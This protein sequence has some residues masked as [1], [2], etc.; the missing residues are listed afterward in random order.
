MSINRT[1]T[2][3]LGLPG[4]TGVLPPKPIVPSNVSQTGLPKTSPTTQV[5]GAILDYL[6]IAAY[7]NATKGCN[8]N[9]NLGGAIP[10]AI[11][12]DGTIITSSSF[13]T[14]GSNGQLL[15]TF[16][17]DI[18]SSVATGTVISQVLYWQLLSQS[19]TPAN[20]PHSSEVSVTSGVTETQAESM[21]LS[22]G[23]KVGFNS[24]ITAEL[25]TELNQ[26]FTQEV[27]ISQ[28]TTLTQQFTFPAL[29]EEQVDGVYQLMRS[30][31]VSPGPNLTQFIAELQFQY[32]ALCGVFPTACLQFNGQFP[33]VYPDSVYLQVAGVDTT[34]TLDPERRLTAEEINEL[35]RPLIP[36]NGQ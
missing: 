4:P 30:F 10:T 16:M 6:P 29:P 18:N 19:V 8:C 31:S 14:K 20:T 12:P 33:F 9:V 22:I 1:I 15:F 13:K 17:G 2:K 7:C 28:A 32:N 26:S 34:S 27:S 23:A 35:V 11:L 24:T 5:D 21:S 36:S 25:S 3:I